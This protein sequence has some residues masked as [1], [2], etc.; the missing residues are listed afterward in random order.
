MLIKSANKLIYIQLFL[1]SN[2]LLR[3]KQQEVTVMT[4]EL[5]VTTESTA[6]ELERAATALLREKGFT[7]WG[8]KYTSEIGK[9]E[10]FIYR[11]KTGAY[12]RSSERRKT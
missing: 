6:A 8:R 11:I 1:S 4:L 7:R 3:R 2:K 9:S 5:K 10:S 12:C